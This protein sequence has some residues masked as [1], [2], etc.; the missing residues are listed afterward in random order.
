[1]SVKLLVAESRSVMAKLFFPV[2]RIMRTNVKI[3][4][5]INV[6][7]CRSFQLTSEM[8]RSII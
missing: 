7:S 8:S 6:K 3:F 4:L 5:Q 2:T 1:M